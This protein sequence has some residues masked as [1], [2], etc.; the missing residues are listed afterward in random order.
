MLKRYDRYRKNGEVK[1]LHQEDFCQALGVSPQQK[2]EKEGGPSLHDSIELIRRISVMPLIDTD[3]FLD[4]VIF[5][6]VSG[7]ADAHAK[8]ISILYAEEGPR[9]SPFYD[10]VCTVIY[11]NL[12]RNLA[13]SIGSKQDPGQISKKEWSALANDIKIGS[14]FLLKK[15]NEKIEMMQSAADRALEIFKEQHGKSEFLNQIRIGIHRRAR[16]SKELLN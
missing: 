1:R 2:Y 11:E 15:V 5:N 3:R 10:L 4:W 13:M 14:S 7:N 6:L 12:D 8:N 16:R 9:L